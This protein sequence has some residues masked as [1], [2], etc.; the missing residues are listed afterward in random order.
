MVTVATVL[1]DTQGV[2]LLLGLMLLINAARQLDLTM[3]VC[4]QKEYWCCATVPSTHCWHIRGTLEH[5]ALRNPPPIL[6]TVLIWHHWTPTC[7]SKWRITCEV[8]FLKLTKFVALYNQQCRTHHFITKVWRLLIKCYDK[9]LDSY[10]DYVEKCPC[11]LHVP[12]SYPCVVY[13]TLC[14]FHIK[15]ESL[16]LWLLF[17]VIFICLLNCKIC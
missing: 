14:I 12:I 4:C 6:A 15:I 2:I 1:W 9:W 5:L 17:K 8:H 10:G 16:T 3:S 13:C 11:I 7:F